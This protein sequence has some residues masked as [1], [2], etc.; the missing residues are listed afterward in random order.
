MM[1]EG[2]LLFGPRMTIPVVSSGSGARSSSGCSWN[3]AGWLV[4][5][6]PLPARSMGLRKL[7]GLRPGDML[8]AR[9]RPSCGREGGAAG[10]QPYSS[11]GR[12][13]GEQLLTKESE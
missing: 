2:A 3:T 12:R 9:W 4:G 8:S 11:F 1:A 7:G 5:G 6:V 10:G 13:G